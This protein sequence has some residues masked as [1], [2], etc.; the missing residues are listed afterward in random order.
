VKEFGL[1]V[2]SA[3]PL[4]DQETGETYNIGVSCM[5]GAKWKIL[6]FPPGCGSFPL[7]ET[8][9]KGKIIATQSCRNKTVIPW[10][11]SFGMTKNYL[12]FIDQ[13]CIFHLTRT[14]LILKVD[15]K[16]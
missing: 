5:S 8:I 9:K 4:T 3:H 7:K 10:F 14:M 12:I 16:D 6:K 13:P 15:F 1:H 11:H 2:I